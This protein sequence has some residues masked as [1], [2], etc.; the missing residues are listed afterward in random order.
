MNLEAA[1]QENTV[2]LRELTAAL[3]ASGAL[4]TAQTS[5]AA[6]SS[7]AVQAVT[8]A[9]K[10][11]AKKE[12][13]AKKSDAPAD[14]TSA[15]TTTASDACVAEKKPWADKTAEKFTEL[16][17]QKATVENLK[18]GIVAISGLVGRPQAEAVLARFGVDAVTEKPGKKHL[19]ESQYVDCFA[20]ML[21]VLV[22]AYD[23]TEAEVAA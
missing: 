8:K 3:V 7:P 2:A 17:G 13:D 6:A 10:D 22:G 12:T 20:M 15:A 1:L 16:Q 23:A 5:S 18:K 9:Q 14:T 19:D 21:R 11:L 4:Q